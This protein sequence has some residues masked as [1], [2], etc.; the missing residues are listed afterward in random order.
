MYVH[1]ILLK[2]YLH[3]LELQVARCCLRLVCQTAML[4]VKHVSMSSKEEFPE[5]SYG[6]DDINYRCCYS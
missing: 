6:N 4:H 1:R 3:V 5:A 2:I